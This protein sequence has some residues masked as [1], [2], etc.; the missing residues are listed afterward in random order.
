MTEMETLTSA[1]QNAYNGTVNHTLG[2]D[3]RSAAS[4]ELN[5]FYK[6]YV[7]QS[8]V[9]DA[10][11]QARQK[12]EAEKEAADLRA[13]VDR[14]RIEAEKEAAKLRAEIDREKLDADRIRAEREA[15]IEREKIQADKE[16]AERDA[17]VEREK[18]K[19]ENKK[20][21][22]NVIVKIVSFIGVIIISVLSLATD[23]DNWI[24]RGSRK[25]ASLIQKFLKL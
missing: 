6:L 16:K 8:K 22:R 24:G 23:S 1:I 7:E 18:I 12:I 13:K 17:E 15:E 3:E 14:E 21:R 10:S 2:T 11:L 25:T 20:D 19:T 4:E 9:D 5:N